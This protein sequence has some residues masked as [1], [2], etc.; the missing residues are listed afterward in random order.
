MNNNNLQPGDIVLL[1]CKVQAVWS[2]KDR[3]VA[4]CPVGSTMKRRRWWWFLPDQLTDV[5][6]KE[7]T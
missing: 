7:R 4:L 6:R 1:P 2:G 3:I 5:E